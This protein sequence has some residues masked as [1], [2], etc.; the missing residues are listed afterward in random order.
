MDDIEIVHGMDLYGRYLEA[1]GRIC[2]G[3]EEDMDGL[4]DAGLAIYRFGYE[5]YVAGRRQMP[6]VFGVDRQAQSLWV[7]G[8]QTAATIDRIKHAN[9]EEG[10]TGA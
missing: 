8:Y 7:C 10:A 5:D 4:I 3:R 2:S 9:C 1:R 6:V